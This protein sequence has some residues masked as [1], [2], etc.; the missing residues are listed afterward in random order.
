MRSFFALLLVVFATWTGFSVD[1]D[2][3]FEVLRSKLE[4][5]G[6]A[7]GYD[8]DGR[9]SVHILQRHFELP[10]GKETL[11]FAQ[12]RNA[13]LQELTFSAIKEIAR[14]K[15][16]ETAEDSRYVV[17]G[18]RIVKAVDKVENCNHSPLGISFGDMAELFSDGRYEI[19]VV[20][21]WSEKLEVAETAAANGRIKPAATY[22]KELH[23]WLNRQDFASLVGT[24][25]F[26]DSK[27]YPHR[28]GIGFG[29]YTGTHADK[30]MAH[31]VAEMTAKKRKEE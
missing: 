27:G 14:F 5:Q 3:A 1:A 30:H 19:A 24:R 8:S 22:S 21:T 7:L 13:A 26:I 9:K 4:R 16:V 10:K 20:V 11:L 23:E 15:C 18:D 6:V 17:D 28:I 2:S 12:F 29:D 31:V 25:V